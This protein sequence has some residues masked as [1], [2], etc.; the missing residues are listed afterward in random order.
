MCSKR[1]LL[2]IETVWNKRKQG[3]TD[4]IL[5]LENVNIVR[6]VEMLNIQ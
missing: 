5:H 3:N 6:N 4:Q 1:D 2:D